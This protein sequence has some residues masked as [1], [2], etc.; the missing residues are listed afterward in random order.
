[1]IVVA[2]SRVTF[3]DLERKFKY[4]VVRGE[5]MLQD[6]T[7]VEKGHECGLALENFEGELQTGDVF[8]TSLS[9]IKSQRERLQSSTGD[10][11]ST[12]PIE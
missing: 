10:Q 6:V 4:R 3:G 2:G 1:M 8:L 11:V 12:N 5:K 9:A 7:K